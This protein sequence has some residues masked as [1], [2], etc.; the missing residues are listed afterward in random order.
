M[1]RDEARLGPVDADHDASESTSALK[2]RDA[3]LDYAAAGM[4]VLPLAGKIPR[5]RGGLT[6]ASSDV[7][8]VAEWWRRWPDANVGVVTGG[9]SGY[10]VVDVD[11]PAGARSLMELERRHGRIRT[12]QV[13]TGSGGRHLWFRCPKDQIRNSAGALGEGLDVRG[14]G[15]YVV[16]PPSVHESGNLYRWTRELEHVAELPAWLLEGARRNGPTPAIEDVIPEGRRDTT[17]TSLAGSM[18]RRGMS[19]AAML[20]ALRV[21]NDR[22]RPP[23]PATDLERIARSVASYPP[24][25][26]EMSVRDPSDSASRKDIQ[27]PTTRLA[28][29]SLAEALSGV[30]QDPEWC[31]RYY[32]APGVTTLYAGRA[33]VGK[34]TLLFGLLG[35]L[36]RGE[37]FLGLATVPTGVL[38]LS[39][40]PAAALRKKADQFGL[41]MSL[42]EPESPSRGETIASRVHLL[43]RAHTQGLRWA[44]IVRQAIAYALE[45]GLGVLVVDTFDKWTGLRGDD[46]NKTGAVLEALEP[47][48]EAA[49]AGLAV[50]VITHHRKGGGKFGEGVRGAS[51]LVGACDIVLE[52]E[53]DPTDETRRRRILRG[54]SRFEEPPELVVELDPNDGYR[55]LGDVEQVRIDDER[56]KLLATLAALP[57]PAL[58]SDVAEALDIAP[59]TARSRLNAARRRGVVF[60][61]GAGKSGDP[62]RW[63]TEREP[64]EE[65]PF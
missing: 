23:L 34:S 48:R 44:E 46:E 43:R 30:H 38:L 54:I 6:N 22:C 65:L 33:K 29:T 36:E 26:S 61:T 25:Q 14:D 35:A 17:L 7:L 39:E 12:A 24:E 1:K 20:A 45:H 2:L 37:S 31:W 63:S 15:G 10:V 11:G 40:E 55:A 52:V 59:G 51:A 62:H 5:N 41:E 19:E 47:L 32:L 56:E 27:T 49:A 60:R 42:R 4:P 58:T 53:R 16:V 9:A 64:T 18:R 8:V 3:A 21:E 13:L 28:F 50:L 57:Q